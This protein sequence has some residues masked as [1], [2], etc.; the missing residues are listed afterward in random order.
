MESPYPGFL[1]RADVAR[2]LA[3]L[4]ILL[5]AAALGI[6]LWLQFRGHVAPCSLCIYQRL[7]DLALMV[8]AGAGLF[9]PAVLRG[10]FWL[11]A[12]LAAGTGAGL[13]GWQWH[14]AHS[15]GAAAEVCT[16]AQLMPPEAFA[17]GSLAGSIAMA[18]SGYGSCA[19]AGQHLWLGIPLAAWSL[20]FFL[21]C[22]LLTG[23]ALALSARARTAS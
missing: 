21:V 22:T 7:A 4:A 6:V 9:L 17:P 16:A 8:L 13:A 2:I 19:I 10:F 14:L 11:L 12:T 23:F 1:K 5:G 3:L 18:L 20:G 15:A